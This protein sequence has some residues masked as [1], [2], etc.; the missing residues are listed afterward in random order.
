MVTLPPATF[1]PVLRGAGR[2]GPPL[3][4]TAAAKA[5]ADFGSDLRMLQAVGAEHA[6]TCTKLLDGGKL[7]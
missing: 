6:A 1:S 5:I 4:P 3:V 7:A 2:T